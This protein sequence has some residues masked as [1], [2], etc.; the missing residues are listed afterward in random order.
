M[1]TLMASYTTGMSQLPVLPVPSR[2]SWKSLVAF[3][4]SYAIQ[5]RRPLIV[6]CAL[7]EKERPMAFS[8]PPTALLCPVPPPD[9]MERWHIKEEDDHVKL[10]LQVPVVSAKDIEVTTTNDVLEIKRKGGAGSGSGQEVAD[11]HGVGEFDIRLLITGQYDPNKVTA[12]LK[13]GMLEVIVYKHQQRKGNPIVLGAP[14]RG[15]DETKQDKNNKPKLGP[16]L[17][18]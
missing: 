6:T 2:S 11:V 16:G 15:P 9:G 3:K 8:I 14:P 10:W 4:T 12:D 17:S 7:P 13:E 1:S 18:S 5:Y